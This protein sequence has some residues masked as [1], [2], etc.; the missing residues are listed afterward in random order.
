MK[1]N[2]KK[3]FED[4]NL[5]PRKSQVEILEFLNKNEQSKYYIIDAPTG[6]GKSHVAL[7]LS[8]SNKIFILTATKY[9]QDLY[10]S[11]FNNDDL[12]MIK[13]KSNYTCYYDEDLTC[14]T[15]KC[16]TDSDLRNDCKSKGICPY[17][18]QLSKAIN[19][20]IIITNY[21]YFLYAID[22]H[23][24]SPRDML[25]CDEAHV[26]EDKIINFSETNL[27]L[28]DI[29]MKFK[30]DFENLKFLNNNESE[31]SITLESIYKKLTSKYEE[32]K[33]I[34]SNII[35]K[36][37]ETSSRMGPR[38]MMSKDDK[39]N[40]AKYTGLYREIGTIIKRLD[41]YFA[42]SK[43]YKW[44]YNVIS[45]NEIFISPYKVSGLFQIYFNGI[46]NKF[47]FM[48]ATMGD[49]NEF[50]EEFNF[51]KKECATLY[52]ESDFDPKNSLVIYT[53]VCKMNYEEINKG[54]PEIAK[55][56]SNILE[57]CHPNEKGI[58]HTTTYNI[59]EYI[60]K[61]IDN[62]RLIYKKMNNEFHSNQKLFEIHKNNSN[63]TVILS[64]SMTEGV[65]LDDELSR[66]QII[67][68]LPFL[69][70][71]N[72]RTKIKMKD[73]NAWYL[74]RMWISFIQSSG[75]STRSNE[76]YSVTYVLDSSFEYFF[77]KSKNKLSK[78]FTDRVVLKY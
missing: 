1:T 19:A 74:S 20:K 49:I 56:V 69:S 61:N 59:A 12:V 18:N 26:L 73:N 23:I 58:I 25:V 72:Y 64:P 43:I 77:N 31:N 22:N 8:D 35:N 13:G 46:A 75:R 70:L 30:I 3:F 60:Y 54:L 55:T 44:I 65:S 2:Y 29:A 57:T 27:N 53:P 40:L 38:F 47:L 42:T 10:L 7:S 37:S 36:Y 78:W 4:N 16:F 48:S 9:L 68:K 66:F 62:N 67:V 17:Y 63:P 41:I 50:I 51:D 33:D 34:V 15:G 5:K 71:A 14:E 24:L 76:D 39:N 52:A 21:D 45:V 28:S 32:Y 11:L 6:C